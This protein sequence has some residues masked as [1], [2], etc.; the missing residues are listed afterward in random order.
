[1]INEEKMYEEVAREYG[2]SLFRQ[3]EEKVVAGI[4]RKD[5]STL[6]RWREKGKVSFVR[7]GDRGV[8]YF[9]LEVAK[10]LVRGVGD[11]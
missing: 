2:F 11:A 5:L 8:R 6:K 1:M 9:G 10:M 7:M 3:Y 4:I